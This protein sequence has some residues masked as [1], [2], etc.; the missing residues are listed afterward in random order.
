M[1]YIYEITNDINNKKYIGKTEGTIEKR[2]QEH[3]RDAFR[4]RCEKRPL[5]AAMRKYGIEHFHV[6]LLEETTDPDVREVYWIEKKQTYHFGYNATLGGDG[7][8]YISAVDVINLY[9]DLHNQKLVAQQLNIS[10]C[11]VRKILKEN[12]INIIKCPTQIKAVAQ[13]TLLG[14][15][16]Q[17]FNSCSNA[18]RYLLCNGYTTA[19]LNT[20]T[21]KITECANGKRKSGYGF[22]WVFVD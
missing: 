21:N 9:N 22:V 20:V 17:I 1:A 15:T 11:S 13:K 8:K 10:E 7:K 6:A 12:A 18:A 3:C 14:E 4:R 16:C 5:Y 2:F 19:K